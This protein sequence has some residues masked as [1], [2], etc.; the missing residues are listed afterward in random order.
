MDQYI[1]TIALT[2]KKECIIKMLNAVISNV[3]LEEAI[4]EDDDLETINSKLTD[5]EGDGVK[6]IG[7]GAFDDCP[8]LKT[9]GK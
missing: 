7:W 3:G 6:T 1:T 8:R 9:I 2:G 5:D 4:A